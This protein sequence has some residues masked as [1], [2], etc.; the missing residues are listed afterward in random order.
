MKV[1]VNGE[2]EVDPKIVGGHLVGEEI[3]LG[4]MET[5][6]ILP[7]HRRRK[8]IAPTPVETDRRREEQRTVRLVIDENVGVEKVKMVGDERNRR[9]EELLLALPKGDFHSRSIVDERRAK[10]KIV[11]GRKSGETGHRLETRRRGDFRG[12]RAEEKNIATVRTRA[13]FIDALP[14]AAGEV[15]PILP[16]EMFF[17]AKRRVDGT[18]TRIG[19]IGHLVRPVETFAFAETGEEKGSRN[20]LP[21]VTSVL[22]VLTSRPFQFFAMH[23]VDGVRLAL[24]LSVA[25]LA[26]VETQRLADVPTV[27]VDEAGKRPLVSLRQGEQIRP[28][29]TE[30]F[31]DDL[32]HR[33]L[34][35]ESERILAESAERPFAAIPNASVRTLSPL[36][37]ILDV[38]FDQ[39]DRRGERKQLF[40]SP[41]LV[42]Q[43]F[44]GPRCSVRIP[45]R[46]RRRAENGSKA[47]RNQ[48]VDRI[49]QV[50]GGEF[51]PGDAMEQAV[52]VGKLLGKRR[53]VS[54]RMDEEGVRDEEE[55]GEEETGEPIDHRD[56]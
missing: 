21:V 37:Q 9:E 46:R 14:V 42:F 17:A 18:S 32:L 27:P 25:D 40:R 50:V 35:D 55:G 47:V 19:E 10:I 54:I 33:Q 23:L 3:Q 36:L 20:A 34:S 7:R 51:F 30:F 38:F 52:R 1:R 39:I 22:V 45:F 15:G 48:L 28:V 44:E 4:A 29:S 11:S 43:L 8:T 2:S 16:A 41:A 5:G 12:D 13:E 24:N 53:F 26:P 49:R 6:E 56:E 31:A